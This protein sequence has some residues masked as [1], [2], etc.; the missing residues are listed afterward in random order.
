[1]NSAAAAAIDPGGSE[2]CPKEGL[3]S[4]SGDTAVIRL[5]PRL[6]ALMDP[7]TKAFVASVGAFRETTAS[8]K[9]LQTTCDEPGPEQ[10]D[11]LLRR[12]LAKLPH[13]FTP[14]DR[15][16]GYRYDVSIPQG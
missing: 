16:A 14:Q 9:P 15:E 11:A 8:H 6:S 12:W 13:P 4:S 1:M 3:R 10:I 7:M 5:P 2:S